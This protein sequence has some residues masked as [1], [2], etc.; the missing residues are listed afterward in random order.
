MR[1]GEFLRDNILFWGVILTHVIGWLVQ[2][3]NI[4]E[5]NVKK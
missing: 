3:Q 2:K 1:K 4:P 5:K